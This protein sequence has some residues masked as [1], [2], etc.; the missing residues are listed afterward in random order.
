MRRD[1][2]LPAHQ[3]SA[4]Q[5]HEI[6]LAGTSGAHRGEEDLADRRQRQKHMSSTVFGG[7]SDPAGVVLRKAK[8]VIGGIKQGGRGGRKERRKEGGKKGRKRERRE[9]RN[10]ERKMFSPC[11]S[12]HKGT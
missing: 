10:E 9:G 2:R 6:H 7:I 1:R 11:H 4:S 3:G 12:S 8:G 5:G